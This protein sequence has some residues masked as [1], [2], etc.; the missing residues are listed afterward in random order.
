MELVGQESTFLSLHF[1]HYDMQLFIIFL[2]SCSQPKD[3]L[4]QL[5]HVAEWIL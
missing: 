1:C 2:Y 3:G 4:T 5:K